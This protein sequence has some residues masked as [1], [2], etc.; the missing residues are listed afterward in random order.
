MGGVQALF[1]VGLFV[2]GVG[3]VIDDSSGTVRGWLVV[4]LGACLVL[5]MIATG[6]RLGLGEPIETS[7]AVLALLA[8][9]LGGLL[10]AFLMALPGADVG[11]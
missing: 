1:G 7:T 11:R 4:V 2:A 5:S 8:T 6:L 9:L 3:A 10:G